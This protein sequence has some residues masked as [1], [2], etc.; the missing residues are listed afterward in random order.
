MV[1]VGINGFGRIGRNVLRAALG[2]PDIQIV[3]INDLTDSKT[4]AHLLKYD[5]LLGT[6]PVAVE[7][8]DGE[9]SVDGQPVIVYS[10]R[11]PA[12][13]PWRDAGVDIVIEATGFFTEREKA[14]VHIH[15][16]G[17]KRVIIS[18]PGKNDDLTIVMG[19]NHALYDPQ[20][21]SVVSN[22]SCTT[23]GLAPAAQVLHQHFGIKHGLMNTTHAYTNSQALHDQPEKD[24]RGARAAAL[25]IVP[26]SSGAAKALGK[27]IPALDGRLTGYSLRVPVPVVSIVDLTVTLE[28]DVTA[29]EV[30]E[31]FRQAA[32][33]GP[34]QGILGYSDEPL[35]SSDYQGDPRSS[36]ID[37]LSTLVIGGNMVKILAWYDNEW[38]FSN[39]LVDLA[40]FMARREQ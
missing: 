2:N 13:I 8:A 16:G 6:L 17:A 15:S 11:D 26:Y 24:L 39:R 19:V 20:H 5:S 38:G 37:G 1:K 28:R 21:H 10:E 29:E 18:A 25:S 27:V 32:A 31:A 23:N 33:A 3:A 4:L 7:A 36:I 14:A 12:R 34:L 30:N 9:L 22:G 40:Q 35:V